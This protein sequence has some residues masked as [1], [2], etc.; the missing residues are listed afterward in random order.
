MKGIL[1][2]LLFSL[3]VCSCSSD[4][5]DD[6]VTEEVV[7][8]NNLLIGDWSADSAIIEG[9]IVSNDSCELGS[10]LIIEEDIFIDRFFQTAG[11][12]CNPIFINGPWELEDDVLTLSRNSGVVYLVWRILELTETTLRI[13]SIGGISDQSW[14]YSK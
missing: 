7:S 4:D 8:E 14:E 5:V 6:L 9:V 10:T 13:E 1:L 12:T 2:L 11:D 3:T